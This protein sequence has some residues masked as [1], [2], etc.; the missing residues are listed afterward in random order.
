M[1]DDMFFTPRKKIVE[2]HQFRAT[3][4]IFD[5]FSHTIK[6]FTFLGAKAA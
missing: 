3:I 1:V 6:N 5:T 4:D 2:I